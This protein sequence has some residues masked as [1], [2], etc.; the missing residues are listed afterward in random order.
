MDSGAWNGGK[1]GVGDC[2][3]VGDVGVEGVQFF[4]CVCPGPGVM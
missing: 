1:G 3:I 4:T 2:G